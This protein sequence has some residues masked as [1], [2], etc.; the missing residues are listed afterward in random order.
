MA[1]VRAARKLVS[2][3]GF[4][5][6]QMVGVAEAAGIA[7]GTL[8]R[9]FGSKSEL[10]IEVVSYVSQREVDAAAGAASGEGTSASRLAA[11]AWTFASR[12]LQGRRLAHALVAEP[13]E[14]EI[15][16]ARLK[17]RRKLARVFES[18]VEQGVRSKEFPAQDVHAAG[19]CMVGCLFEGLVGP[20]ALDS[21]TTDLERENHAIA[22]VGFCMR[23]V[24]GRP[25]TFTP[26]TRKR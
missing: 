12:A 24:S 26:V 18:V 25:D 10:M 4:R 1:I 23:G 16:A 5:E 6:A 13:V 17:Y 22:I 3:V 19:A 14:P 15:E 9:H 7:L 20:L 21:L 8:Y 2:A 11:S